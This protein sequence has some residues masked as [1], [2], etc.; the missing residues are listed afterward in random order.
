MTYSTHPR[1]EQM[2]WKQTCFFIDE[3]LC[4]SPGEEIEGIFKLSLIG[5]KKIA[6]QID[7][8]F[9]GEVNQL[10]KSFDYLL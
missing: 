6:F 1:E 10:E 5:R 2:R 3:C 9:Q 8:D 7:V 4:V